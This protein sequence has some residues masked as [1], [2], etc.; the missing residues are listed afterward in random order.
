MNFK[1]A[2]P[3]IDSVPGW[4]LKDECKLLFENARDCKAEGVIME[5]G[6]YL[7]RSTSA[8]CLGTLATTPPGKPTMVYTVDPHHGW[9]RKKGGSTYPEF[10][11]HMKRLH[12]M[13]VVKPITGTSE[14][15]HVDWNKPIRFLF[16]DG[17]HDYPAVKLDYDLWVPHV[18]K[19]GVIAL[20]DTATWDGPK[21]VIADAWKGKNIIRTCEI[22][23]IIRE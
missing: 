1:E 14:Q 2:W 7:G 3:L 8:L 20:H 23:A 15:A 4:M 16:I 5:I 10:I 19:G 22:S 13:S 9:P 21:K 11:L 12:L 17:M 18:T 6:S